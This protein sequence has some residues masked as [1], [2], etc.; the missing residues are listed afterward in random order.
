MNHRKAMPANGSRFKEKEIVFKWFMTAVAG[1]SG[2]A[3]IE[4]Q[5][6]SR[7]VMNN[8]EKTI[9]AMAAAR[10]VLMR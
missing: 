5:I 1:P 2:L 4:I 10:G 8:N 3:G 6:S 7:L 9:P